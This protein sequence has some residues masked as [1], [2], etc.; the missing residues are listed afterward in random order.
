[1]PLNLTKK[2]RVRVASGEVIPSE[3]QCT[4]VRLMIQGTAF[5]VEVHVLVL[6]RCYMVLMGF[7]NLTMKSYVEEKIVEMQG[8]AASKLNEEGSLNKCNKSETRW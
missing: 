3:G 1:M 8:L 7:Q 2:V 6:A 5:T 4:R